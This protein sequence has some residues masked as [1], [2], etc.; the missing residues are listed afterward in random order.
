MEEGE[1][2]QGVVMGVAGRGKR[3]C[4]RRRWAWAF[5]WGLGSW[6]A[7]GIGDACACDVRW[8]NRFMGAANRTA[9]GVELLCSAFT[10]HNQVHAVFEMQCS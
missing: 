10:V 5:C 9:A 1:G 4:R 7:Q 2:V 6:P 8:T 3:Y